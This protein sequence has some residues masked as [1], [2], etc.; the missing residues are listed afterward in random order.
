MASVF[1]VAHKVLK[2]NRDNVVAATFMGSQKT[3]AFGLPLIKAL[4][5]A[6]TDLAWFCL[7]IL[8]YHPL[9]TFLGTAMVPIL[10]E[11][12]ESGSRRV[13]VSV[14]ESSVSGGEGS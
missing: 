12:V 5:G 4:F 7:P 6:S 10:R 11:F 3:L 9:Q 2:L 8:V 1:F 13:D 14:D